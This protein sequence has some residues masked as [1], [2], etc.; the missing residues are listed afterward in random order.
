[1]N[2]PTTAIPPHTTQTD[3][4]GVEIRQPPGTIDDWLAHGF[5]STGGWRT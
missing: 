2:G 1:V 3:F 4:D 5:V